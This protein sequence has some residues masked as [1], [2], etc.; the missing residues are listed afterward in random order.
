MLN[1]KTEALA[2]L[3]R[4]IDDGWR[5]AWWLTAADPTLESIVDHPDFIAMVDEVEADVAGQ[6]KQVRE[7]ERNGEFAPVPDVVVIQSR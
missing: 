2:A 7:L 3:R 4:A 1:R 5:E 6:L